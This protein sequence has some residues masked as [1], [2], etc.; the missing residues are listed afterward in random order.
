MKLTVCFVVF[1]LLFLVSSQEVKKNELIIINDYR[2]GVRGFNAYLYPIPNTNKYILIDTLSENRHHIIQEELKKRNIKMDD[3]ALVFITHYHNDHAGNCQILQ[4]EI[5]APFACPI[6]E[7]KYL[8]TGTA[9]PPVHSLYS[10]VKFIASFLSVKSPAY[11][12]KLQYRGGEILKEYGD[13]KILHTPG[14]TNGS[15]SIIGNDGNCFIGDI[16][17]GNFW[18]K[19]DPKLHLLLVYESY[20]KVLNS[21]KLLLNEKCERFHSGHGYEFDRASLIKFIENHKEELLMNKKIERD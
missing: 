4:K 20:P 12:S 3:I 11:E 7:C 18:K 1:C 19:N 10:F 16:L 13:I 9:I 8:T 21:L 15:L 5:K 17:W 14:H 6:M 2:V